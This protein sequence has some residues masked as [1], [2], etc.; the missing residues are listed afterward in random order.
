MTAIP[1]I[2]RRGGFRYVQRCSLLAAC[3]GESAAVTVRMRTLGQCQED[4]RP[5]CAGHIAKERAFCD[6][7]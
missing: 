2:L 5:L 1:A 6:C 4:R 3:F 7:L